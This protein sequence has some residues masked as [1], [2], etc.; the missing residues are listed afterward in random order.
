MGFFYMLF[1]LPAEGTNLTC[2]ENY[3]YL[4]LGFHNLTSRSAGK[5]TGEQGKTAA[6]NIA[7]EQLRTPSLRDI[8][9][10]IRIHRKQRRT[11]RALNR[12][13]LDFRSDDPAAIESA[14]SRMTA[15]EFEAI[16][17]RQ[18]FSNWIFIG[19]A[20]NG[21]VPDRPLEVIDV[22]VGTGTSTRVLAHYLPKGSR[23]RGYDLSEPLMRVAADQVY[24]HHSGQEVE[25]VFHAQ[26][27]TETFRKGDGTAVA[28]ASVDYINSSGI[29]G[30]HLDTPQL[31]AFAEE[32]K[33][34]LRPGA[35]VALDIGPAFTENEM[36]EIQAK[37]G[38]TPVKWVRIHRS[39]R[40]GQLIF[41]S[42][43]RPW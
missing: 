31:E 22:G 8:F 12:R 9:D 39:A 30:H 17:G 33:R 3:E 16:N 7:P 25:T 28:T 42:A 19:H 5:T 35:H 13:G 18:Q 2:L 40:I 36:I 27:I 14:Y 41:Q 43:T 34:V 21:L 11:E 4:S 1:L 15:E 20:L 37:F 24:R 32:A 23:I 6:L 29:I 38:L 26:S 10:F